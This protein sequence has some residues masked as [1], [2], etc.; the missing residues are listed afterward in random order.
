MVNDILDLSKIEAGKIK[1][2]KK[3]FSLNKMISNMV[4]NIENLA[5]K[6]DLELVLNISSDLDFIKADEMRIKQIL[7]NLLSNAIK[8]TGEGKRIGIDTCAVDSD[9]AISVWDEGQGISS[10]NLEKFLEPFEQLSPG[11]SEKPEGTVSTWQ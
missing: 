5:K 10:E 9:A 6:K 3:P 11:Y 1:I 8:F 4:S 2:E 7:Y